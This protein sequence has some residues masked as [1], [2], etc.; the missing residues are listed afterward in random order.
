LTVSE[1]LISYP[2]PYR[3]GRQL[4]EVADVDAAYPEVTRDSGRRVVGMRVMEGTGRHNRKLLRII[5]LNYTRSGQPM[6]SSSGTVVV[7]NT[8]ESLR[9]AIRAVRPQEL[10]R[11]QAIDSEIERLRLDRQEV[12]KLAWQRGHVVGVG[13]LR[14]KADRHLERRSSG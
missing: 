14:Q 6:A 1:Y 10:E 7:Q 9:T 12:L 8:A 13:E 3:R 2:R 5:G 4:I 11:L